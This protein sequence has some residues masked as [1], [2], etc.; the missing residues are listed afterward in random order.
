MAVL[1]LSGIAFLSLHVW[2]GGKFGGWKGRRGMGTK[3]EEEEEEEEDEGKGRKRRFAREEEEEKEEEEGECA[4]KRRTVKDRRRRESPAGR[5]GGRGRGGKQR[6]LMYRY[7]RSFRDGLRRGGGNREPKI[8]GC[9]IKTRIAQLMG[10]LQVKAQVAIFSLFFFRR[11]VYALV[12]LYL[13][14]DA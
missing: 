2:S 9:A 7:R 3:E 4:A 14:G 6:R 1:R 12:C 13:Y 10:R 11:C 8:L 5:E